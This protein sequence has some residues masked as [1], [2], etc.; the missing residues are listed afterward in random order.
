DVELVDSSLADLARSA[1]PGRLLAPLLL[2]GDGSRQDNAQPVPATAATALY[3]VLPGA[4]L[5][6][7][8][9]R[10]TEPW[11]SR[12]PPRVGWAAAAR[13]PSPDPPTRRMR[14]TPV[15]GSPPPRPA[16]RPPTHKA[17]PMAAR[18]SSSPARSRG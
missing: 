11:Q 4:A 7:R 10:I 15:P 8:L 1:E 9:R 5:P 12:T 17:S 13:S 14:P 2:D 3:A 18:A 16:S 6:G